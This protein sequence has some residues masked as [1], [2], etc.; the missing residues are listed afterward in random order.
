MS[1]APL[2]IMVTK[3]GKRLRPCEWTPSRLESAK[4]WAQSRA[5]VF[6]NPSF[7]NARERV[8]ISSEW[9]ILSI[10]FCDR[11]PAHFFAR[12]MKRWG[13]IVDVIL[14]L[15]FHRHENFNPFP[16]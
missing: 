7:W 3:R 15:E 4:S 8:S 6:S 5:R 9:G 10:M 13:P 14:L 2:L 1:M 11:E 16:L 12:S